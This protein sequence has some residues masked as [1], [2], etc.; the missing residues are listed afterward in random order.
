MILRFTILWGL[1]DMMA[2]DWQRLKIWQACQN[3][4]DYVE[5]AQACEAEGCAPL[6]ALEFAQKA[7]MVS[8]GATTFPDLPVSEAYLKFL[9][10]NREVPRTQPVPPGSPGAA[11]AQTGGCGSCGGGQIR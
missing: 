9:Q 8:C 6:P 10:E 5:F 4:F 11:P 2:N 1:S 3:K 7:G